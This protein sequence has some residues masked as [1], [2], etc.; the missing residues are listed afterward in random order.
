MVRYADDFVMLCRSEAEAQRALT[1][2]A[3]WTQQAGLTLHPQKTRVVDA[4]QRGGFDFLG[5][6]FERRLHVGRGRRACRKLKETLRAK[7]RRNNGQSVGGHHRGR[8][9]HGA[10]LV[11]VFSTQP[12]ATTFAPLDAMASHAPAQCSA[13][14][15]G[16]GGG[17]D[18][19]A[20]ISA[21]PTHSL[22]RRGSLT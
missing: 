11:C 8:E 9:S 7:T 12:R 4:T 21:G 15:Y 16:I 6:H 3:T 22:R 5:Y 2:V 18:G 19:G 20:I 1:L 13:P 17:A 14:T 10:G